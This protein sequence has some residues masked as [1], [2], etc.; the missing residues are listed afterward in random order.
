MKKRIVL[1]PKPWGWTRLIA[2]LALA[3]LAAS[4][5]QAQSGVAGVGTVEV[6][7][8]TLLDGVGVPLSEV[9]ALVQSLH[10]ADIAAQNPG[11]LA[12]LLNQNLGAVSVSNGT[13]NPYQTDVNYRG[14]QATSLL[15]A[16]LFIW[17]VWKDRKRWL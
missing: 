9:P 14:F 6:V 4:P 16:P 11:N 3:G 2:A 8:Q 13:G 5:A 15:G 7:G 12:D 17:L 10:A 1:A